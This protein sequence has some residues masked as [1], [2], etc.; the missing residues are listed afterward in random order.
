MAL[1]QRAA[2]RAR[3]LSTVSSAMVGFLDFNRLICIMWW[4]G[5]QWKK[6]VWFFRLNRKCIAYQNKLIEFHNANEK[7]KYHISEKTAGKDQVPATAQGT[8]C[9]SSCSRQRPKDAFCKCSGSGSL[10]YASVYFC[11]RNMYRKTNAICESVNC[12]AYETFIKNLILWQCSL[13]ANAHEMWP[14]GNFSLVEGLVLNAVCS[15]KPKMCTRL[16]F[17][18]KTRNDRT[19]LYLWNSYVPVL[20][21]DP[22]F[23]RR[24]WYSCASLARSTFWRSTFNFFRCFWLSI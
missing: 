14:V 12:K 23:S 20:F 8:S 11:E 2:S 4:L 9:P 18:E 3:K 6:I 7:S 21:P 5:S 24:A 10:W 13:F 1:L 17:N 19:K 15:E 22:S 16:N